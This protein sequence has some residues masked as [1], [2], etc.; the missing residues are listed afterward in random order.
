APR[1]VFPCSGEDRWVAINVTSDAQWR[2]LGRV[3]GA[4]AWAEDPRFATVAG[5]LAHQDELETA[6]AAWTRTRTPHEVA[7]RLQQAGVAAGAAAGRRCAVR[8]S[9]R[10]PE[11]HLGAAAAT[12]AEC[13]ATGRRRAGRADV[14]GSCAAGPP[15]ADRPDGA[16]WLS[17]PGP[18]RS[19]QRVRQQ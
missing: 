1:G 3:A 6:L 17:S 9:P 13:G 16:G 11:P 8:R 4:P 10:T 7:I 15:C 5:R 14:N 18:E 2:A 19:A 12:I